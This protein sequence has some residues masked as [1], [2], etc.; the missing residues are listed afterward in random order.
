MF[1]SEVGIGEIFEDKCGVPYEKI[2]MYASIN[3]LTGRTEHHNCISLWDFTE[4]YFR[5]D[6]G[7]FEH[8]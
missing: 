5:D 6:E 2:E 1:F 8:V 7:V 4:C 3:Q